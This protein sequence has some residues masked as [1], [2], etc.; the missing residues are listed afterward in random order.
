[1]RSLAKESEIIGESR[2]PAI[3]SGNESSAQMHIRNIFHIFPINTPPIRV[4]GYEESDE[5]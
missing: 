5:T 4:R 1:M 2:D 3:K